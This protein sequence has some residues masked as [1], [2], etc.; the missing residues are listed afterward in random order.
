MILQQ[1]YTGNHFIPEAKYQEILILNVQ[2]LVDVTFQCV[3]LIEQLLSN[4][5]M[6]KMIKF[7]IDFIIYRICIYMYFGYLIISFK[8]S[9]YPTGA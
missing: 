7:S 5:K 1:V 8:S 4:V 2:R 6:L 9:L 3:Y